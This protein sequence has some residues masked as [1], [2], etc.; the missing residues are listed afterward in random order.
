MNKYPNL[1]NENEIEIFETVFG[2]MISHLVTE[3][4][5]YANRDKNDP[6]FNISYEEMMRFLG[7][8][9]ISGYNIRTAERDYWSK[10]PDLDHYSLI[11]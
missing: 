4:N 10:S 2:N 5:R 11:Q 9:I 6:A 7:L 3:T 8:I 1:T